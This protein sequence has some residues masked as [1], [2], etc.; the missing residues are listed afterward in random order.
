M[1]GLNMKMKIIFPFLILSMNLYPQV[2][3]IESRSY[4]KQG[5]FEVNFS[6]NLGAGFPSFES[7][8]SNEYYSVYDSRPFN[9]LITASIGICVLDGL[10]VEPELDI[11]LITDSE[12][13]ISLL[14]K[15]Y[16]QF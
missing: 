11:N 14:G 3:E 1:I 5:D 8:K 2:R 7:S 9:F 15:S 4:F 16:I 10:T 13:S 6:T 12:V